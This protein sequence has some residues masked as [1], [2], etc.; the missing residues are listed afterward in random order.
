MDA[1]KEKLLDQYMEQLLTSF[2]DVGQM[3][4]E[5][6]IFNSLNKIRSLLGELYEDSRTD[7]KDELKR[8]QKMN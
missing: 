4:T 5:G 7:L 2:K 3:K 8:V 6:Q 1:K